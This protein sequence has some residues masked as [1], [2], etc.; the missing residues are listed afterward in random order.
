MSCKH[1]SFYIWKFCQET[2]NKDSS[3][4]HI[5]LWLQSLFFCSAFIQHPR[6]HPR[7][8]RFSLLIL[9]L[10]IPLLQ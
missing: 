3:Y 1:H 2:V 4:F 8:L 9:L 7:N 5:K 10:L 6:I